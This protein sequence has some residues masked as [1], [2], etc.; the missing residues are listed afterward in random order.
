MDPRPPK[1][2]RAVALKYDPLKQ[3]APR[4]IAKGQ[5]AMAERILATA[6]ENGIPLYK[7]PE[8]IEILSQLDVGLEIEPDLYQA[9]AEV[10]I[11]IYKMNQKKIQ[12]VKTAS[13]KGK[14]RQAQT[15]R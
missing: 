2:V 12:Q 13:L 7:D 5:G 4:V 9:V 6:F 1:R 3:Q 11:F 15:V 14:S 10:L 8:L